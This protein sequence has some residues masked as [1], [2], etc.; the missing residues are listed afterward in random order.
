MPLVLGVANRPVQGAVPNI[1]N[2]GVGNI[3]ATALGGI[4][5][6][7]LADLGI[8]DLFAVGAPGCGARATLDLL[9]V[10]VVTGPIHTYSLAIPVTPILYGF[11][12]FT[13]AAVLVPGVNSLL[14]G[15]LTSNGIRGMIGNL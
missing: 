2:L 9:N 6:I 11:S 15:T 13:Q 14:G 8:P 1:W 5:I 12:L 10:W 3:P 4:E 7:G